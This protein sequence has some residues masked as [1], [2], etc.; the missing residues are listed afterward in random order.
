MGDQDEQ[1]PTV[2]VA[3]MSGLAAEAVFGAVVV[4]QHYSHAPD[5]FEDAKTEAAKPG[6]N[7]RRKEI[8]FCVCFAESYLYEWVLGDVLG[9]DLTKLPTYFPENRRRGIYDKWKDIPKQLKGEGLI[10]AVPDASDAH[11][12]DWRRL[13]EYRDGLIHA[14]ASKPQ[15][16][17]FMPKPTKTELD[18]LAPGWA[19]GVVVEHVRRLNTA[20]GTK[21]PAWFAV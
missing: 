19:F 11:G 8:V 2:H 16:G 13:T 6:A 10:A 12:R 20:A 3:T 9:R 17:G 5:W 14:V 18:Q 15:G 21:L 4:W 1:K 7:A